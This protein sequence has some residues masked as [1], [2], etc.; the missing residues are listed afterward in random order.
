M[1]TKERL[2]ELIEQEATIWDDVHCQIKLINDSKHKIK[3]LAN[4]LYVAEQFENC[5]TTHTWWEDYTIGFYDLYENEED[6]KWEEEFGC[7]ERTERLK[8]PTW[9]TFRV[10][11]GFSFYD[12]KHNPISMIICLDPV[13]VAPCNDCIYIAD[14]KKEYFCKPKTKEN[15]YDACR[16]AKELFLGEKK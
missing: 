9:E 5:A 7:I 16:K 15:Y 8:L 10:I 12:Y 14:S 1:I 2:K 6:S 3:L 4:A 13:N 11:G